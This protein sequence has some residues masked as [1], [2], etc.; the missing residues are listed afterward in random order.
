M[1]QRHPAHERA[2]FW[3]QRVQHGSDEGYVAAHTIA[4]LYA[5]LT[6][7]AFRPILKPAVVREMIEHNV[8][9]RMRVITL[10]Q[11]D[12]KDIITHLTDLSLIGGVTYDALI[13]WA[14]KKCG[15]D[16]LMTL[17]PKDFRRVL[18]E[19]AEIVVVP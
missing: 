19:M 12:Y 17:N 7:L 4:E 5:V 14:A 13:M 6:T 8:T 9:S 2:I 11:E 15:A 10:T 3:L 1:V 18:P 16:Q